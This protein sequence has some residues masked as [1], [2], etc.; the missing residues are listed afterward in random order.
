MTRGEIPRD[1]R[2]VVVGAG[3]GG[4]CAAWYLK[5]AGFKRVQVLEKSPQLGGKCRSLTV[6]S[7]SFDL[8][9]NY[10][11]SA[12]K[13]VRALAAHVGAGMYTEKA[14]HVINVQ[15][16]QLRSILSQ[17]LSHTSIF[18]LGWQSLRYALIRWRL[19]NLLSPVQPGFAHVQDHPELQ[20]NF[21][22]WLRRHRLEA[23]IPTFE[24]PLTLMGYGQLRD[25]A[26][27]YALT[28][29]SLGTFRDLGMFAANFP[30]RW[31]P[32]RFNQ[33]YG[34]MFE[35]LA[36]EVDVLTGV[37]IKEIT[38]DDKITVRFRVLEQDLE[39]E[40]SDDE[41]ATY[42]YLILACPQ[43]PT[44][45]GQFLEL[46]A[47]E[48]TLFEQVLV[49]PFFLTT[50]KAPGTTRVAAVSFS[51][52]EPDMGQP[53]VVTRQYPE[54]DFISIYTR[55]DREGTI[56]REKVEANNAA[57]LA[58]IGAKHPRRHHFF[59]DE[60]AYFPHVSPAAVDAGFYTALDALQGR[61]RTFYCGGLLAFELVETI[62]EQAHHLVE[63]HF[64][65]SSRQ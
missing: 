19:R 21:E 27:V 2:I 57:F 65:G 56:D 63:T 22:D 3:A 35:R 47:E 48:R 40:T 51:L 43:L 59:S 9:A 24:I 4:L 11:T 54:N 64:S 49:N 7:Q 20:G 1:A 23:L 46:S 60:W 13:R 34:R 12:Y 5:L 16:G 31:W 50:Y 36:A 38:R 6:D 17:L 62:A 30:L 42:D 52:P 44:L 45:L 28:Y 53:F 14:G 15:T 39:G 33:G 61:N 25:I 58:A 26:T 32:K 29:M 8:G 18:T 10:I 55:G 41:V 37:T